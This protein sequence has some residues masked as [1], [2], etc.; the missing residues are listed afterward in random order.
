MATTTGVLAATTPATYSTGSSTTPKEM[1]AT[2]ANFLYTAAPGT[3][4]VVVHSMDATTGALTAHASISFS[5]TASTVLFTD[6]T[7]A[8]LYQITASVLYGYT[9]N[10]STGD[11]AVIA[12]FPTINPA[13]LVYRGCFSADAAFMYL[14]VGNTL[15]GYS[16][17]SSTGIP[18]ALSPASVATGTLPKSCNSIKIAQ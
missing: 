13:S 17:S 9:V 2:S 16:V 10:S 4:K 8:F 15:Q 12:S 11:I 5:T 18:T 3:S 1:A 6:P 7:S 14:P